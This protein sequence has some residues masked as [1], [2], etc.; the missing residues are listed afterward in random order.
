MATSS[1]KSK[2]KSAAYRLV[3]EETGYQYIARLGRE[4][5]D[6][7]KDKKIRKYVPKLRKHADFVVRKVK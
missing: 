7:L 4:A 6:K 3:N 2:K 1:K 5:Y